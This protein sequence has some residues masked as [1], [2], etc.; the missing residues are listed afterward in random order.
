MDGDLIA[1]PT[2]PPVRLDL[3][4]GQHPR[5]GFAGVDLY[6]PGAERVDLRVYPWPWA[7]AS[8]AEAHCSHYV[9][10]IP[11]DEVH[12]GP[13]DGQDAFF[14]FFDELHRVLE[15][16]GVATIIVPCGRSSR[17]FMDPTHR[18]FIMAETFGYLA[19]DWRKAQGLDHYRVACDFGIVVNPTVDQSMN[20]LHP[21]AAARRFN[22]GWNTIHD[23]VAV[24]TKR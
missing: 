9:E 21:E 10:H 16:G 22:E 5:E 17:G 18:R 15:P 2:A 11:A 23:W 4:C 6:A 1:P 24:L 8:V 14:A 13:R 3:A 20:L 7:D 19:A 12:G